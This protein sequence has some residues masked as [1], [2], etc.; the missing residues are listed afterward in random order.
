MRRGQRRDRVENRV[1]IGASLL[2]IL[3]ER[4]D[5]H[6]RARVFLGRRR[7]QRRG[8]V[9]RGRGF[10][11]RLPAAIERDPLGLAPRLELLAFRVEL[12]G[13]LLQHLGL[14]RIERDLLLPPVDLELVRVHGLAGLGGRRIGRRQLDANASQL[15]LDFGETRRR[16]RFVRARFVQ[17]RARRFD[18]FRQA[19]ITPREEHLLPAPHLVAQPRV[20]AG[21][22]GLALQRSALLVDLVNDVFE[23]R[24]VLLRRFELELGGAPPGLV[25]RDARGFLDQLT[26]IGRDASSGSSRSCPAR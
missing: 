26:P 23:A 16:R 17:S 22:R 19:A 5:R 18:R 9:P 2:D 8:L 7:C 10:R 24:E 11:R 20:A 21:F 14:L 13:A 15:V 3:L 25:F 6:P 4:F 12:L 1:D